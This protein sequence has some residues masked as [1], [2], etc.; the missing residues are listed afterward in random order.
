MQ[1]G[2]RKSAMQVVA[3]R[4]QKKNN[5]ELSPD[6]YR[7]P[8]PRFVA[9][10]RKRPGEGHRHILKKSDIYK[11]LELL[12][13]WDEL[14]IGLNA[15]VLAPAEYNTA[16]YHVPGV[17]HVCAWDADL[18]Q[19]L[20]PNHYMAHK[21]IYARFGVIGEL[22]DQNDYL[23]KFDEDAVRGYQLLHILLHEL[24]HHHDRMTSRLQKKAGRGERYAEEYARQYEA[25]IWNDYVKAFR[26]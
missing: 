17:A 18:W 19:Y 2:N 14:A 21:D 15:I 20:T 22:T 12:P 3:G 4:V 10:D 16:G 5:W 6:Y 1:R 7:A 11:F 23:C 24:G 9:I 25:K 13:D 26:L 8:Q